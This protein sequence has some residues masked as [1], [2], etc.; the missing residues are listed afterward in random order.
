MYT[1][2]RE[3]KKKK[4]YLPNAKPSTIWLRMTVKLT[5]FAASSNTNIEA[6]NNTT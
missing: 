3:K 2:Y 5:L 4:L 6:I 1:S